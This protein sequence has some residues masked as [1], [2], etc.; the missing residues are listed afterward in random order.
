MQ[1]YNLN[2]GLIQSICEGGNQ[3]GSFH[4]LTAL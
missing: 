3:L 4:E 2:F 1:H